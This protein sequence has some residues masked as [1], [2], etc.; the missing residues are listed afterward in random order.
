MR[1][2]RNVLGV[3]HKS[4]KRG[5]LP[6]TLSAPGTPTRILHHLL[7]VLLLHV[8]RDLRVSVLLGTLYAR[9]W[10]WLLSSPTTRVPHASM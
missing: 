3:V 2:H 1:A 6:T 10:G 8:P 9:A 4:A 5:R 7:V